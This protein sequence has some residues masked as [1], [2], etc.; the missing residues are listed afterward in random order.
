MTIVQIMELIL[1]M[2]NNDKYIVCNASNVCDKILFNQKGWQTLDSIFSVDC[3]ANI[4]S[5]FY[6]IVFYYQVDITSNNATIYLVLH[7]VLST[8]LQHAL[9]IKYIVSFEHW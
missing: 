3:G 5:V 4:L 6:G 7:K 8:I 1:D 9:Q 2:F